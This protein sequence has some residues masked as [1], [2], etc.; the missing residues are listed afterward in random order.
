M[1]TTD[2]GPIRQ[3]AGQRYLIITAKHHDGDGGGNDWDYDESKKDFAGYVE[4]YV[5]PQVRELLTNYG[6]CGRAR[7]ARDWPPCYRPNPEPG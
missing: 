5:K 3:G 2:E 1:T 7:V 4:R 6:P